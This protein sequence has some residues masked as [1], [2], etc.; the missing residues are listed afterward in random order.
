M[1]EDKHNFEAPKVFRVE[2]NTDAV[3]VLPPTPTFPAGIILR[4]GLNTPDASTNAVPGTYFDELYAVEKARGKGKPPHYPG[5]SL[6]KQLLEPVHIQSWNGRRY[7]PRI[8]I[9]HEEM[10]DRVDGRVPESLDS[11]PVAAAKA[12]IDAYASDK[13]A[14]RRWTK[15]RDKDVAL[16][17][18][19]KLASRGA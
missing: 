3:I 5:R 19:Q 6:I 2:N 12:I 10:A 13:D 14:L 16:F 7:G 18:K 9:Y 15:S 8:S 1:A 17:A 4:P 11:F